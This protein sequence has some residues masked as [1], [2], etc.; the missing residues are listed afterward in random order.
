MHNSNVI[1]TTKV[2]TL[3]AASNVGFPYMNP[4]DAGAHLR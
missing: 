1:P 4:R 3:V 2:Y